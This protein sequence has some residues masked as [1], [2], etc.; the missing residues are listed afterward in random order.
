MFGIVLALTVSLLAAHHPAIAPDFTDEAALR[1]PKLSSFHL[2]EDSGS[3]NQPNAGVSLN[4]MLADPPPEEEGDAN[5]DGVRHAEEDE[6]VEIMNH[7]STPL[8]IAGW[9]IRDEVSV[10]HVFPDTA[11]LILEPGSLATV[12]GGGTPT[13]F[14]GLVSVASSG[15]LSLNNGGDTVTLVSSY[16]ETADTHVYGAEGGR[17][18][19]MIR[20]PDGT[21]AWCLAGD[22]G[23]ISPHS[24][25]RMNGGT[26]AR[27]SLS[28]GEVKLEF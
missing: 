14:D 28:W 1:I 8:D 7:G 18:R 27:E 26:T 11:P 16:G 19:S 6:F 9:E 5:G 25:H 20:I 23:S 22:G 3:V 21:G 15:R 10:R 4:E 17:D 2:A 12:F 24:A 13:G